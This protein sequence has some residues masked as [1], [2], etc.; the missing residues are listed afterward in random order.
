MGRPTI[1]K[2]QTMALAVLEEAA[3]R[4]RH[5]PQSQTRGIALA[6]ACLAYFAR[7]FDRYHFDRFWR[8]LNDGCRVRRSAEASAAL[9]GIYANLGRTREVKIMS[10]FE[11]EAD[12]V[13][14]PPDGYPRQ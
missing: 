14:G 2:L 10:A 3:A 12:K 7:P 5:E 9:N 4:C 8:A 13:D 6:L 11:L 1:E